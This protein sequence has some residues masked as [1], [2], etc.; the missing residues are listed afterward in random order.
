MPIIWAFADSSSITL[1]TA[2]DFDANDLKEYTEQFYMSGKSP[3]TYDD[4]FAEHLMDIGISQ[5]LVRE[6]LG[7]TWA[8]LYFKVIQKRLYAKKEEEQSE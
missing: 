4:E 7:E 5:D 1:K 2:L 6:A 3:Y 8:T